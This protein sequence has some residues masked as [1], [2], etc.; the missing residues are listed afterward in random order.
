MNAYMWQGLK[1][2]R[3]YRLINPFLRE[4]LKG[5]AKYSSLPLA[6]DGSKSWAHIHVPIH[7][8]TGVHVHMLA[9]N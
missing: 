9:M 2:R 3:I 1:Y 4:G 5:I 6:L 8:Y 7:V